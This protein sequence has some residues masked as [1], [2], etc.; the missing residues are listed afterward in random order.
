MQH[1]TQDMIPRRTVL[2]SAILIA[3]GGTAQAANFTVSDE[4]TLITA[5]KTANTNNED[6]I[7]QIPANTTI[8]LTRFLPLINSNINI[9]GADQATS[10]VDG[11]N[12]GDRIFF[13]RS[14]TVS[15]SN[16]T[17]KNG[18]A[19]GGGAGGEGGSGG[20]GGGAGLGGALFIYDGSVSIENVIFENNRAF[21]GG[22]SSPNSN[23][24]GGGGGGM[25][26]KGG[27][28]VEGGGGGG[29]GLF[30]NGGYSGGGGG[31][32]YSG[33]SA[34]AAYGG[35]GGGGYTGAGLTASDDG[36]NGGPNGTDGT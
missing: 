7:I 31:G 34:F 2:A 35:G 18:T 27:A 10:I 9:E 8:S 36:G 24:A 23:Y 17:L 15:F 5:I 26:G 13:V 22:G 16:L 12:T 29:G 30:G 33:G 14:G 6:D 19:L 1:T 11:N 3:L 25:G 4:T 21:G 20:G 28:G 32:F